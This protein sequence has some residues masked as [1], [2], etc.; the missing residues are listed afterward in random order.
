MVI[1]KY[2]AFV[3]A[4]FSFWLAMICLGCHVAG[5]KIRSFIRRAPRDQFMC[6]ASCACMAWGRRSFRLIAWIMSIK[7]VV[8]YDGPLP[9]PPCIAIA[10]HVS[11]LDITLVPAM[12]EE[13]GFSNV[14]WAVKKP[15]R[16]FP[17]IGW[18]AH[19]IGC[20]F[21]ARDRNPDDIEAMRRCGAMALRQKAGFAVFVEGTRF[22]ILNLLKAAGFK[23]VLPP[24]TGGFN[25]LREVMP[26]APVLV[27]T[28]QYPK[29][30][31]DGSSRSLAQAAALYGAT[32]TVT[33]TLFSAETVNADPNWLINTW[34]AVDA[35]LDTDQL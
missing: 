2:A 26:D 5:L 1:R 35:S 14:R 3:C 20:A 10:N 13:H 33:M 23:N 17:I 24:K 22:V 11:V 21:L 8:R 4:F 30:V 7:T 19:E 27:L 16:S 12:L 6:E 29:R 32:I 28:M 18:C 31:R 15:V 34:K 25:A 9:I